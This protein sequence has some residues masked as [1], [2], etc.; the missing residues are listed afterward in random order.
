MSR[1]FARDQP[2]VVPTDTVYGLMAPIDRPAAIARIFELK[3]RPVDQPL[4]VLIGE[5]SELGLVA[6]PSPT[7][8]ALAAR[9]WPGALTMVVEAGV[10]IGQRVGAHDGTI[11]VRCADDELVR[12]ITAAVGPV[13][14]T[15]AN[16]HGRPTPISAA[17]IAHQLTDVLVIDDGPRPAPP[18]AV[19]RVGVDGDIEVLRPGAINPEALRQVA[20]G[21][22]TI[23]PPLTNDGENGVRS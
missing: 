9:F 7:A 22:T 3:G 10:G 11:G 16:V 20:R 15:S 13:A 19:V 17:E 18:S 4:A 2:A 14:T 5:P 8:T 6:E 1:A 12:R 21:P 23:P